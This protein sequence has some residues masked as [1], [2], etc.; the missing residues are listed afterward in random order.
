MSLVVPV[1]FHI[2]A[3]LAV[4]VYRSLTWE[5]ADFIICRLPATRKLL[6]IYGKVIAGILGII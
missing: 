5:A 2:A 6:G 4:C 3:A 1:I